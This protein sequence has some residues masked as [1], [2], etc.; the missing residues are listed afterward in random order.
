M[1]PPLTKPVILRGHATT[2]R[3]FQDLRQGGGSKIFFYPTYI[4]FTHPVPPLPVMLSNKLKAKNSI[5]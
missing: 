3:R 2:H 1:T 5:Y 4:D